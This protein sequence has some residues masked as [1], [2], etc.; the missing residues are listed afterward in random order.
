MVKHIIVFMTYKKGQH[1]RLYTDHKTSHK[2][3][4][5]PL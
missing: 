1:I 5:D 2:T 4:S 3:C